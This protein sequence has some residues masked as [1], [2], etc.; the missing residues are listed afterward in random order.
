MKWKSQIC[1]PKIYHKLYSCNSIFLLIGHKFGKRGEVFSSLWRKAPN[2]SSASYWL[3]NNFL[4]SPHSHVI[5]SHTYRNC[6]HGWPLCCR[7]IASTRQSRLLRLYYISA[8]FPKIALT[9]KVTNW[10]LYR[11]QTEIFLGD[12]FLNNRRIMK[13]ISR[14]KSPWH[15]G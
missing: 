4:K 9:T 7:T 13:T 12:S 1:G 15:N 2:L 14:K 6:S 3:T 8:L 5:V 11:L 10:K